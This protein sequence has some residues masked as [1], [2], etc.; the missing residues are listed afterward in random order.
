VRALI[1]DCVYLLKTYQQLD[2]E[3]RERVR[4]PCITG[5]WPAFGQA[6]RPAVSSRRP[7]SSSASG[8]LGE[9]SSAAGEFGLRQ[10]LC[11]SS[12]SQQR[13][14]R[15]Q[16][17]LV[18]RLCHTHSMGEVSIEGRD[19]STSKAG[20]TM[21]E[22]GFLGLLRRAALIAALAGA[23]GS[24][25]LTLR[26]GRRQNSRILLL[27]FTI[28][29]LSPFIALVAASLVSKR[30]SILTR[31]TLYCVT[32]IL[33]LGSLAVYGDVA[34][35]YTT[36]KAGFVFLVVPLASWLLIAIVVPI[37]ALISS[38]LSGRG[39]GA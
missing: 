22:R 4:N 35:G 34:F 29:A 7:P 14:L 39:D 11:W 23:A 38:R 33:T 8:E 13:A 10:N 30:W 26:A 15:S 3:N 37:A 25:G 16:L 18:Q 28:W 36:A 24:L 5:S 12:T 9:A 19:E 31:A 27:L 17:A 21:P 2:Y 1:G 20:P 32:L 6:M